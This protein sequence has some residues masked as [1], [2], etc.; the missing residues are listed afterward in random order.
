MIQFK[1]QIAKDIKSVFINP[2]E[3][4]EPHDIDGVQVVCVVDTDLIHQM[5]SPVQGATFGN[6]IQIHVQESEFDMIPVRGQLMRV[7]GTIYIVQEV[8]QNIGML[9]ITL[10]GAEQ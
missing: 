9:T 10:E 6:Q 5:N 8:A 4:A 2:D 7:D 1:A 3:F